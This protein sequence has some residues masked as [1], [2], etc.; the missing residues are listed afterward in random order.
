MAEGPGGATQVL[1]STSGGTTRAGPAEHP[2]FFD[3][4]LAHAEQTATGMLAVAQ[5]AR[6]RFYV[7]AG[8]LAAVL[9]AADPVVTSNGDRLRFE[10]FSA[11]CG[12]YAR[13]DLLAG[14]LDGTVLDTGT[15][16]V[17]FNPAM[18][19]ALALVA[20]LDPIGLQVGDVSRPSTISGHMAL[21][22]GSAPKRCANSRPCRYNA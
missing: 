11:C 4:F 2:R 22:T 10:S 19:D 16:N 21:V 7:P 6:T 3:G 20:G 13:L 1:L 14:A 12:V 5:V 15:T 8:M 17:D 18:R 9:R